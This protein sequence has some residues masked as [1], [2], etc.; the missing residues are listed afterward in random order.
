MRLVFFLEYGAPECGV[1]I[2]SRLVVI[3]SPAVEIIE[4]ESQSYVFSGIDRIKC[5][6]A[7]FAIVTST[8]FMITDV[9][10]R[11]K[12]IGEIYVRKR[13]KEIIV[14]VVEE[15]VAEAYGA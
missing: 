5:F 10:D 14:G 9:C 15:K 11:G 7:V 1:E 4:F 3:K 8:T 2:G 6:D 12:G 13:C